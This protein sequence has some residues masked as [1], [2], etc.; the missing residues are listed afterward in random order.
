MARVEYKKKQKVSMRL[1]RFV[2]TLLRNRKTK[3]GSSAATRRAQSLVEFAVFLPIFIMLVSGITEFGFMLNYYLTLLDGTRES[4][5]LFSNFTPF[6][7]P[8]TGQNC[9][10]DGDANCDNEAFY[11]GA[12]A[13]VIDAIEPLE[14]DPAA[15]DVIIS[16]FSITE[17]GSVSRFP[18]DTGEWRWYNNHASRLSTEEIA[19]RL[20]TNAPATGALL[21]EVFYDYHQV[22]K[23]PWLLVFVSDPVTLH[24]YSIMPLSAAEPTPTPMSP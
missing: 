6:E 3:A 4:A 22:L 7:E 10:F 23:L 11:Q 19:S 21:V 17:D 13:A 1:V 5:R 18:S 12:A 24:A 16:V 20:N 2:R 15:D 8:P 14:L 9:N